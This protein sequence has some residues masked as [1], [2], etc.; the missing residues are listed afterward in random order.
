MLVH[1]G[2]PLIEDRAGLL[3]VLIRILFG[4][5]N[6]LVC[7]GSLARVDADVGIEGGL[8]LR[9]MSRSVGWPIMQDSRGSFAPAETR[10]RSII[11]Q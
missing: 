9:G 8:A 10:G 5:V 4:G 2:K 1:C 7:Q 3:K 6:V 11:W